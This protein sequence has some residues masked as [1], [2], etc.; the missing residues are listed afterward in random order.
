MS[1][2]V[3]ILI[4]VS[5][6]KQDTLRQLFELKGYCRKNRYRIVR[7]ISGKLSGKSN[8]RPDLAELLAAAEKREFTKVLV[9]EISRLGRRAKDI[10]HTIDRLH[11]QKISVVFKNLGGLESLD[12]DGKETFVTNIIVA[13]HAELAQEEGKLISERTKSGLAAARARG[14]TLGRPQ[15]KEKQKIFLQKYPGLIADLKKGLSLRQCA[16]LHRLSRNTVI[17]VKKTI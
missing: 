9:T 6:Q 17:K 15:G 16:I 4:R 11:A 2:P 8:H 1:T 5:S 12:E 13:I 10:R 14:I 7:T 3:C